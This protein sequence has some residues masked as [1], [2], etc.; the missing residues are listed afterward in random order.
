M[1]ND[2]KKRLKEILTS[3][4]KL[5]QRIA[6]AL[7]EQNL[8]FSGISELSE[9]LNVP[10]SSLSRFVAAINYKSFKFFLFE[11]LDSKAEGIV[12]SKDEEK[13]NE[14]SKSKVTKKIEDIVSKTG[15]NVYLLTSKR[16]RCIGK[17]MDERLENGGIKSELFSGQTSEIEKFVSKIS[18][19]DTLILV[20]LSGYSFQVSEAI[21]AVARRKEGTRPVIIIITVAKYMKVFNKYPYIY[22]T[23]FTNSYITDDSNWIVYNSVIN[24]I[25]P[26]IG[27]I[28]N[29]IYN[30]YHS[31]EIEK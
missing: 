17:F 22:V 9:I 8:E 30:K 14:P 13:N 16:S 31:R 21:Q 18:K 3:G 2:C 10:I 11:Y 15:G 23:K 6:L 27:E 26:I 4:T 12:W 29:G 5:H 24:E 25:M 1:T 28:L 20:T 19:D 7:I